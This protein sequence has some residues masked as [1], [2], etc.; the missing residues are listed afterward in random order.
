MLAHRNGVMVG[1]NAFPIGTG[2]IKWNADHGLSADIFY[3]HLFIAPSPHRLS[4]SIAFSF[5]RGSII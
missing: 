1:L 4:R 5:F 3:E 2:G